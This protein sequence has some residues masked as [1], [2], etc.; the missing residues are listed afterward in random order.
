LRVVDN[1]GLDECPGGFRS[2]TRVESTPVRPRRFGAKKSAK[3][4]VISTCWKVVLW[5]ILSHWSRDK[6]EW[7]T[8]RPRN[9]RRDKGNDGRWQNPDTIKRST[10]RGKH[11]GEK[12]GKNQGYFRVASGRVKQRITIRKSGYRKK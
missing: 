4:G 7:K 5:R 2:R 12:K 10:A 8:A 1:S 9:C 6:S 3:R 11:G